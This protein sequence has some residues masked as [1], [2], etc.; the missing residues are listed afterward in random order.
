VL[1]FYEFNTLNES[2]LLD[3]ILTG[4]ECEHVRFFE[5]RIVYPEK[6]K[7][8]TICIYCYSLKKNKQL[9]TLIS[10]LR[11]Y[12][13]EENHEILSFCEKN[14]LTINLKDS[15]NP[16]KDNFKEFAAKR[17]KCLIV[18]DEIVEFES[19]LEVIEKRLFNDQRNTVECNYCGFKMEPSFKKCTNCILTEKDNECADKKFKKAKNY[20]FIEKLKLEKI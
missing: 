15:E 7:N 10:N 3:K 14:E 18:G 19:F 12:N 13:D 8:L 4:L 16:F 20:N 17:E 11:N 1:T 6:I 9:V 2:S 5:N